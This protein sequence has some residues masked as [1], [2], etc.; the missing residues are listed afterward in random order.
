MPWNEGRPDAVISVPRWLMAVLDLVGPVLGKLLLA[1]A[2]LLLL[3]PLV[4]VCI[5]SFNDVPQATV[6]GF[7]AFTLEWYRRVL[8]GGAYGAAFVTSVQLACVPASWRSR[9]AAGGVRAGAPALSRPDRAR[10]LL[11]AAAVA[12]AYG[13]RRWNAAAA[14]GLHC[15]A[16]LFRAD[17]GACRADP[18]LR[19][20]ASADLRRTAR[21][22]A[23]GGSRE[24]WSEYPQAGWC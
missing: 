17:G 19:H 5:Q 3:L 23:G 24:S 18:A 13:D 7:R 2:L 20:R 10:R 6:A 14:A 21:Q 12:A 16:A 9:C 15:A 8:F 11:D 22:G 1:C 4:L